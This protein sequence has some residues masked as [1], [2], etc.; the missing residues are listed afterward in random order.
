MK[1]RVVVSQ[2]LLGVPCRYDGKCA[3]R[4][5]VCAQACQRGW[6]PICP[7]ILG[8]LS[9]PRAAAE[10]CKERVMNCDGEDVTAAF[11]RGANE[12]L[13]LAKLYGAKYAVLKEKSPSCGCGLIY[14]GTFSG[15][16]IDGNGV[17]AE[18][19]L[20]NGIEVFGESRLNELLDRIEKEEIQ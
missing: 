4:E 16:K 3:E 7:E 20:Q 12:A 5:E 17:T 9:T 18:L 1:E 10:R 6:I 11:V 15:V 13:R 19:F 14:D 8:G 2:C